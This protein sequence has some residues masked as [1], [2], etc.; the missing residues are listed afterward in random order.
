MIFNKKPDITLTWEWPDERKSETQIKIKVESIKPQ[1]KGI[2]GVNKSP[3][4]LGWIPD[5]VVLNGI[6]TNND[7]SLTGKTISI[8]LP[9]EEIKDISAGDILSLGLVDSEVC[10]EVSK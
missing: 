6:I 5:G 10:I 1:S 4:V 2:F 3:S 7:E 9:E 8:I